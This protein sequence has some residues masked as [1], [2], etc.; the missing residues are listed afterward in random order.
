MSLEDRALLVKASSRQSRVRIP[1]MEALTG[2]R[3]LFA[4]YV[5]TY[6]FFGASSVA[7]TICRHR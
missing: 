1:K 5:V 7:H 6:H 4:I 3:G 2:A